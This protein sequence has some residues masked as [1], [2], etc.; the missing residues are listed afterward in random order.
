MDKELLKQ[1]HKMSVNNGEI[2]KDSK[3]LGCFQCGAVVS[4]GEVVDYIQDVG[5]TDMCPNCS[6]D[7]LISF[8]VILKALNSEYIWT[9]SEL[10][11]DISE[12]LI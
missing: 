1:L 7:S 10:E 11:V 2:N 8:D 9:G 3:V 12:G 5:V 6:V 4:P